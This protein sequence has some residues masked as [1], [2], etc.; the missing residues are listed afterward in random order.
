MNKL[1][2][3]N[4]LSIKEI[5]KQFKNKDIYYTPQE[6]DE[7]TI[8]LADIKY[9]NTYDPICEQCILPIDISE[10]VYQ[11]ILKKTK[12]NIIS[13]ETKEKQEKLL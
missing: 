2:T 8:S 7:C 11:D 4:E 1:E 12:K 3:D 9:N 10:L 6:L 13:Q 5:K